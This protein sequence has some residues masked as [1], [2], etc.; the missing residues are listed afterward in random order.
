M[1]PANTETVFSPI[2][3]EAGEVVAIRKWEEEQFALPFVVD[4]IIDFTTA[5]QLIAS[6][7]LEL[8][9]IKAT[10]ANEVSA[11]HARYAAEIDAA[12]KVISERLEAAYA[13]AAKNE[14]SVFSD[15]KTLSLPLAEVSF[16]DCPPSVE[17]VEGW[18]L[19]GVIAALRKWKGLRYLRV[20]FE[21]KKR[22][23]TADREKIKPFV[24]A[25]RGVRITNNKSLTIA[26][27]A[28]PDAKVSLVR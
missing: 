13:W 1:A 25:R 16:K 27:A 28:N 4:S 11:V 2:R 24:W 3:N 23:I 15:A 7:K 17:L 12:Q 26:P 21:L 5:V 9:S 20:S 6:K 18:K 8:E 22:A 14:A 10:Q 19:S